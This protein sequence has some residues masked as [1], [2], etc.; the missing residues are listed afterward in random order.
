ME[1]RQAP[2]TV[3]SVV[4]LWF[5]AWAVYFFVYPELARSAEVKP[6]QQEVRAQTI[7]ALDQEILS[8]LTQRC[9]ASSKSFLTQRLQILLAEYDNKSD[10]PYPRPLPSCEELN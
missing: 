8:V 7:K 4:C 1:A 9:K 3:A 2:F 10:K 6:I 5:V